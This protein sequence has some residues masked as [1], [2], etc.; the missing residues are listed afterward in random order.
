MN[1]ILIGII[2][3]VGIATSWCASKQL[4]YVM[5]SKQGFN[6]AYFIMWYQTSFISL[7]LLY[8]MITCQNIR[9]SLAK[10]KI[11]ILRLVSLG[12]LFFLIWLISNY[13]AIL[14]LQNISG[15]FF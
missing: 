3:V 12:F 8:P 9:S 15:F 10:D 13:L 1:K 14:A 4:T 2:L 5:Q 11:S 7:S 6:A